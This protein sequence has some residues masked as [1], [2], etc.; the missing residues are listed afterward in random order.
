MGQAAKRK[1]LRT[2]WTQLTDFLELGPV[3]LETLRCFFL[4]HQANPWMNLSQ[5]VAAIFAP[6]GPPFFLAMPIELRHLIFRLTDQLDPN[7]RR[8]LKV[9]RG[10]SLEDWRDAWI[11]TQKKG[12]DDIPLVLGTPPSLPSV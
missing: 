4:M 6:Y 7:I 5:Y 9:T 2:T 12:E 11:F 8:T 1:I 10:I 3:H